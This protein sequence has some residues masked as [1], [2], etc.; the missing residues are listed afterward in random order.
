MEHLILYKSPFFKERIGNANDGGYIIAILPGDY[1]LFL[2]GGI[3]ND[4]TFETE[5]LNLYPGMVCYAF[6]GTV[7]GLPDSD[8][9]DDRIH[10]VKKNLGNVQ[11]DSVTNMHEYMESYNNIFENGYRRP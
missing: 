3:S 8:N 7:S 5:L 11:T 4:I 6:D 2:S 1:D 9:I 10:F